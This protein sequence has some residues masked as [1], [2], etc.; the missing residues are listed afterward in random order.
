MCF[1]YTSTNA[2][3][4]NNI[5]G[6]KYIAICERNDPIVSLLVRYL[7]EI[8]RARRLNRMKQIAATAAY[9]NL[10]IGERPSDRKAE[11]LKY[12]P[13]D[14][15]KNHGIIVPIMSGTEISYKWQVFSG[16]L[17]TL[18]D[19]GF[20][21]RALYELLRRRAERYD[22]SESLTAEDKSSF[23]T[24]ANKNSKAKDDAPSGSVA[25]RW[26]CGSDKKKWKAW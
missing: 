4:V 2:K 18:N 9:H 19:A 6:K 15:E 3:D 17:A 12:F 14:C 11:N 22:L 20:P 1:G 16:F 10:P 8:M 23:T 26:K 24:L 13:H 25:I 21:R 5:V 7:D